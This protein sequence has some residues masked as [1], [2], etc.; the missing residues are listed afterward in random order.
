MTVKNSQLILADESID[1]QSGALVSNSS[2]VELLVNSLQEDN[3]NDLPKIGR[4]F[5]S[6]A[7]ILVDLDQ[8]TFTLW[9]ANPS[10]TEELVSMGAT[11]SSSVTSQ[12]P[13]SQPVDS[14][15][16][17]GGGIGGIVVGVVAILA[18]MIAL[19]W[20]IKQRK[21]KNAHAQA[22]HTL[23]SDQSERSDKKIGEFSDEPQEA[24][25]RPTEIK[26]SE[27]LPT[28]TDRTQ[29]VPG[30]HEMQAV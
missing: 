24:D 29:A 5:L 6:G 30:V 16:L 26:Q 22:T 27:Q 23:V 9:A 19:T 20:V 21:K 13:S 3:D 1:K 8:N 15:R 4:P 18:I 17:G 12:P 10:G 14:S 25:S 2:V 7:Y 28:Y 11:C